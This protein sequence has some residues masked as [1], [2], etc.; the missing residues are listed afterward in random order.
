MHGSPN[1]YSLTGEYFMYPCKRCKYGQG[2]SPRAAHGG[3]C[4]D[5]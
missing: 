1:V 4:E 2:Q 5:E 3:P